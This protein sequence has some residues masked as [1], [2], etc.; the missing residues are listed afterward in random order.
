ML[1]ILISLVVNLFVFP[2]WAGD[3]V[4]KRFKKSMRSLAVLLRTEID[5]F[6]FYHHENIENLNINEFAKTKKSELKDSLKKAQAVFS[7]ITNYM[8]YSQYE[9]SYS[10]LSSSECNVIMVYIKK[11]LQHLVIV[12]GICDGILDRSDE[13]PDPNHPLNQALE[14]FLLDAIGILRYIYGCIDKNYAEDFQDK[15]DDYLPN[16]INENQPA[17]KQSFNWFST[18]FSLRKRKNLDKLLRKFSLKPSEVPRPKL[19]TSQSVSLEEECE[20]IIKQLNCKDQ[21]LFDEFYFL[22]ALISFYS[23]LKEFSSFIADV[24]SKKILHIPFLYN[25]ESYER[26][27][28]FSN[29]E[30]NHFH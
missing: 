4:R 10:Y 25:H 16:W 27:H 5:V 21:K 2:Y 23:R 24:S 29:H 8:R 20:K 30:S 15:S 26:F 11:L 3:Y 12:A 19:L 1:G 13:L 14:L 6:Q 18:L 28:D 22:L 17:P 9:V 7:E